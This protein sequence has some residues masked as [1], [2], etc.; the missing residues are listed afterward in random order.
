MQNHLTDETASF[1]KRMVNVNEA[2]QSF[3]GICEELAKANS[4]VKN[5]T[6]ELLISVNQTREDSKATRELVE[7]IQAQSDQSRSSMSE[8]AG[9]ASAIDQIA[10][11]IGSIAMQTKLLSLN[12]SVE[13]A[14]AGEHGKGFAV[15]AAEVRE[16]AEQTN[17]SL[18]SVKKA[19]DELMQCSSDCTAS[20]DAMAGKVA[21]LIEK[22]ERVDKSSGE[23]MNTCQ[24]LQRRTDD[25][26][27][28]SNVVQTVFENIAE[29]AKSDLRTAQKIDELARRE[30][31]SRLAG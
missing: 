15:V 29:G 14:R 12:A 8:L 11:V 21:A 23:Q 24:E 16:L 9:A 7:A 27:K 1:V 2:C 4:A 30:D 22:S 28:H 6:S 10:V 13:A 19:I 31:I 18:A 5:A 26:A 20:L 17:S 25:T 3:T